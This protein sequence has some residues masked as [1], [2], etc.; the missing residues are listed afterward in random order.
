MYCLQQVIARQSAGGQVFMGEVDVALGE[1]HRRLPPPK[2]HL[3]GRERGVEKGGVLGRSRG[4]S[5]MAVLDVVP[6]QRRRCRY[7]AW[8]VS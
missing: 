7:E 1:T 8:R 4:I 6:G 3:L 2:K 5:G